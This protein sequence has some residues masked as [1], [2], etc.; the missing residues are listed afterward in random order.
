MLPPTTFAN[1][2]LYFAN[3]IIEIFNTRL[4][5][6]LSTYRVLNY[7]SIASYKFWIVINI[8]IGLGFGSLLRK[9]KMEVVGIIVLLTMLAGAF[10]NLNINPFCYGIFSIGL[11]LSFS[12]DNIFEQSLSSSFSF[13][14]GISVS[15]IIVVALNT[16]F[17]GNENIYN[18]KE[19]VKNTCNYARFGKDTLPQGDM[20]LASGL[21]GDEDNGA[22]IIDGGLDQEV[23]LRGFVGSS[24]E[25]NEWLILDGSSYTGDMNGFLRWLNE[26][27]FSSQYQYSSYSLA[28]KISNADEKKLITIDNDGAYRKYVYLPYE[29][30]DLTSGNSHENRDWQIT[31]IDLFGAT[32]YSFEMTGASNSSDN[33]IYNDID[34]SNNSNAKFIETEAVY[35]SF[36]KK[37]YLQITDHEKKVIEEEII[38]NLDLSKAD[39]SQITSKIRLSLL[40]SNN[41]AQDV[42]TKYD[43][44]INF[45]DWFTAGGKNCNS[46]YYATIGVLAYRAAGIPARYVE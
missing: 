40:A 33:I 18:I 37:N 41:I 10:F 43:G 24:F 21:I 16:G 15:A 6:S 5:M 7:S 39:L 31:S 8:L 32:K 42:A 38:G 28:A 29:A 30:I 1:G 11:L 9:G 13:V 45:V 17:I 44:S 20:T 19:G 26:N 3:Q 34:V 12:G 22:L 27:D 46:A 23:Y 35:K 14:L 25:K 36:V 2:F 4:N